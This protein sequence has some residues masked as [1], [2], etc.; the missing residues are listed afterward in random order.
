MDDVLAAVPHP[1]GVAHIQ[2]EGQ[3][4]LVFT[5]LLARLERR[6]SSWAAL[7]GMEK[8]DPMLTQSAHVGFALPV[9]KVGWGVSI[10]LTVS[11]SSLRRWQEHEA[12]IA[13]AEAE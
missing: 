6:A 10:S 4:G 11:A 12:A 5:T 7:S 2:K 13:V 1:S 3:A 8:L 9:I